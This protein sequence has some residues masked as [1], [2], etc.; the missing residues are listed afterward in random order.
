MQTKHRIMI[1]IKHLT[2]TKLQNDLSRLTFQ[3]DYKG[4]TNFKCELV[5]NLSWLFGNLQEISVGNYHL[6]EGS[7]KETFHIDIPNK[8]AKK[9]SRFNW[10]LIGFA[11]FNG[12]YSRL[13]GKGKMSPLNLSS[14]LEQ[15]LHS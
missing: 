1:E 15:L 5:I 8:I 6:Q 10:Q 2:T 3:M 12:Q 11:S 14:Y 13:K 4:G 9:S 7:L